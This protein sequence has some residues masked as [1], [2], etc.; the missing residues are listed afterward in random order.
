MRKLNLVILCLLMTIMSFSQVRLTQEQY[1]NLP[2]DVKS[3]IQSQVSRDNE[4]ENKVKT[5][6]KWAGYRKEI[7]TAVNECLKAV[8]GSAERI[9]NTELGR[10]AIKLTVWKLLWKDIVGIA[11]GLLVF[12]TSVIIGCIIVRN[13]VKMIEKSEKNRDISG[14]SIGWTFA[15][16]VILII[17]GTGIT[18]TIMF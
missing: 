9:S 18:C 10:V 17:V 15:F 8:E 12:L 1:N 11:L 13:G 3:A 14:E 2:E 6:S 4:I 7:G 16:G 5:A